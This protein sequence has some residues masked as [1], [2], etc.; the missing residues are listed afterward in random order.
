[1][2]TI[3]IVTDISGRRCWAWWL[4][5]RNSCWCLPLAVTAVD[6]YNHYCYRYFWETV[7]SMVTSLQKQLLMFTIIIVTDIS[8]RQ[9]W[10]WWLVYSNSCWCLPLAVTAVDVYNHYYYRYFWETVLSMVT[11]LQQQL[12]MFSTGSDSC[13]CLQSLLLQIFLGDG[14]EHGD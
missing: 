7:L 12:L 13:W 14:T 11:S 5:Y 1:M 9:Y 3:I 2:F 10:A 6:V 8:G 4:V